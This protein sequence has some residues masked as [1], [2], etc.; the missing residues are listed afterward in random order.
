MAAV[1][2]SAA[3]RIAKAA[4]E[5]SVARMRSLERDLKASREF[6]KRLQQQL[7]DAQNMLYDYIED[8]TEVEES[9]PEV[10][11]YLLAD[12]LRHI[13]IA[14]PG[15]LPVALTQGLTQEQALEIAGI[16]ADDTQQIIE[17]DRK[18]H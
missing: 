14:T 10:W 15:G 13:A 12:L 11:L 1:G 6:N 16:I 2:D 7:E 9:K 17:G 5:K 3:L 8:A 18:C 4:L